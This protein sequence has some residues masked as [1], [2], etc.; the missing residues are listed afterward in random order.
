MG[1]V[2][3]TLQ[4]HQTCP[5]KNDDTILTDAH[6]DQLEKFFGNKKI[7]LTKLYSSS[8]DDCNFNE[9]HSSTENTP[10]TLVV[11]KTINNTIIGAYKEISCPSR[12]V[13]PGYW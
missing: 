3:G 9:I 1:L 8:R 13:L 7:N 5:A 2:R 11:A 6:V 12:A 4:G 10:R